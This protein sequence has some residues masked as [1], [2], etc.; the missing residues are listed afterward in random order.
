MGG[1]GGGLFIINSQSMFLNGLVDVSGKTGANNGDG[2]G[3]GGAGGGVNLTAQVFNGTGTV[4]AMGGPGGEN[5]G[6]GG[7]G[8]RVSVAIGQSGSACGLAYDVSGGTGTSSSG[9]SGTVSSTETI[10]TPT[11]LTAVWPSSYS[12]HW[13]WQLSNGA[14][15]YQIYSSTGGDGQS[16]LLGAA[17]TSYTTIE[18]AANTT[19]T[20]LVRARS[21]GAQADS[22]QL[23]L[24]TLAKSPTA[25]ASSFLNAHPSSATVAWA[26]L[27][28]SPDSLSSRGY[29]LEASS[30]N[31]GALTPGGDTLSS[32][33]P[34]VALSTLA[35][36][37]LLANTTYFFRAASL[38]W[39]G[40]TSPY[41]SLGSTSSLADFVGQAQ[42]YALN[43]TSVT[44]N[45]AELSNSRGYRLD[46]S[47]SADFSGETFSSQTANVSLSTLTRTGLTSET[48]Y[49]VRLG[50]LN[51]T[52]LPNWVSLGYVVTK[53]TTPPA[54]VSSILAET[55]S[56]E[57]YLDMS[58][59]APGDNGLSGCVTDGRY[60]VD[61]STDP[62][63]KFST[64]TYQV[65]FSSSF[66]PGDQQ[67]RL[68]TGLMPNSTYFVRVFALDEVLLGGPLSE[69]A[70]APTLPLPVATL[71]PAE[72][73]FLG[74]FQSSITAAWGALPGPPDA[75]S[76]TA[77]GYKLEA[78]STNFGAL[79]PG[80]VVYSSQTLNVAAST[81]TVIDLASEVTFY[82]RVGSIGH[83]SERNYRTLGSTK[84]VAFMGAPPD[85][86]AVS[87]VW[88]SS[89]SLTWLTVNS[90]GYRVDAST[91]EDF[92]GDIFSSVT[93]N[94]GLGSLTVKNLDPNTTYFFKVGAVWGELTNYS[95]ER[96]T[97]PTLASSAG[98]MQF[99][100]VFYT[101]AT[102]TW[103]PHP[104]SPPD[105]S[106]K[107]C[108][109]Y[110]LE[111]S[112]AADFTGDLVSSAT[113]NAA[114]STLTVPNVP[115][116]SLN[117]TYFYR[118]GALNWAGATNYALLGATAT[119]AN[120]PQAAAP[121]FL[122][123]FETS[124]TAQWTAGAP[125]NPAGTRYRLDASSTNFGV[126]SPGGDTLS[127]TT[128]N[129]QAVVSSLL[130]DTTYF[131]RV[132]AL[133][134]NSAASLLV[135]SSTSTLAGLPTLL[136]DTF[137]A[138][139]QTSATLAWAALPAG[140]DPATAAYGYRLEASST[141]F[142]A[143]LAG[144]QVYSSQTANVAL[145]TLTVSAPALDRNTTYYFRVG[146]LNWN[147]HPNFAV[148]GSSSTAAGSVSS[149]QVFRSFESS[150]TLNWQA[151][152][153]GPQ[154][155]TSEG[156]RL[157]ASSTNFGALLP[158]GA[159]L[160]SATPNVALS[161]LTS[162]GLLPNTTYFYRAG[163]LNWAGHPNFTGGFSSAT[164]ASQVSDAAFFQVDNT[165]VTAS[166]TPVSSQGYDLQASVNAS[167][168]PIAG[169]S[170]TANGSVSR[171][172]VLAGL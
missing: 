164:L 170:L 37:S 98:G 74:V 171:L 24:A 32:A 122:S 85:N 112:T 80:G 12:I 55:G 45:W 64:A 93:T 59:T 44:A 11:G 113:F 117:T 78:S 34:N 161:T 142:G 30:T 19:H 133:N 7:G 63:F 121:T 155:S 141:N 79:F 162:A 138:V 128:L 145:S 107:T 94:G 146:S 143:V 123:V 35:I 4:K 71:G 118:V 111:A 159:V 83:N 58:W 2:D 70:T 16:P 124:V 39:A 51:W 38:N 10:A 106:S 167:F 56:S 166:W 46:L 154:S 108:A 57:S 147:S 73:T 95:I 47:P 36:P 102:A 1:P 69:G 135:L 40:S 54:A 22:A 114:L 160:S 49:H 66:C 119:L 72:K 5:K 136:S 97:A 87:K 158:G 14:A 131:Y 42:V 156:Y 43:G 48:G 168:S 9:A 20:F 137:L 26:A 67:S 41:T 127:S 90:N 109:G 120:F 157:E 29:L 62:A 126:L 61:Y 101:S 77:E 23:G 82:F 150:A 115:G 86:V 91:D 18:L 88:L 31:F 6:G 165:S 116:L 151:L 68:L 152:P 105:A 13:T 53:D 110:V 50:A 132:T 148:L 15:S 84:T 172:S 139:H 144:G 76:K 52:G 89:I 21:C 140:P 103:V 104:A 149:I 25:L 169:S 65:D 129:T 134:H 153:A 163:A 60:R 125:A 33:T 99:K 3:G 92:D 75:S 130:R 27:P 81:L 28:A 17:A 96:A 100:L 8:G